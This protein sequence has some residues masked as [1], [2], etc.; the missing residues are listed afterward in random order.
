VIGDGPERDSLQQ[1]FG[2]VAGAPAI[3]WTGY[4]DDVR[5][6]LTAADVYVNSSTHEGVSLTILEAMAA[7][8]P[9]VAT[10]AGGTPEVVLD[11]ET[12]MLVGV[13]SPNSLAAAME[14]LAR[15]PALR[16]SMGEAGRFRVKHHFSLDAMAGSYLRAYRGHLD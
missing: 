12:G 8:I 2:G 1:Q 5:R 16:R 6:L 15:D 14:T 11:G 13:R 3:T 7:A 9:V 10:R 4:R